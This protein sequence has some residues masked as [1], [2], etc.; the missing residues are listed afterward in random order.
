MDGKNIVHHFLKLIIVKIA[1]KGALDND[2]LSVKPEFQ[3]GDFNEPIQQ[4]V[5]CSQ[6]KR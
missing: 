1:P 5:G 6:L 2:W 3:K 4:M